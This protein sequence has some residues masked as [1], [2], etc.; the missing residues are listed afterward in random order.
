MKKALMPKFIAILLLVILSITMFYAFR[1]KD[2]KVNISANIYNETQ[3]EITGLNMFIKFKNIDETKDILNK[4][5]LQPKHKIERS[6][7]IK[8]DKLFS[9]HIH[10]KDKDKS[11]YYVA[12][13]NPRNMDIKLYITHYNEISKEVEINWEIIIDK[14]ENTIKGREKL[15][16]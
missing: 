9:I 16:L 10:D 3:H 4:I 14:S 1:Y 6:V 7:S 11:I 2:K 12:A 5:T 8:G 13:S 15:R